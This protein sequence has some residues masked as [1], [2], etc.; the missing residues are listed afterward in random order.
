M[1]SR[2]GLEKVVGSWIGSWMVE[3]FDKSEE[4][5]TSL[6]CNK[7]LSSISHPSAAAFTKLS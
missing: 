1:R 3:I 2:M 7:N 6:E 4:S 5:E